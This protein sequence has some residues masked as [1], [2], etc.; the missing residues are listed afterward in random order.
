MPKPSHAEQHTSCEVLIVGAGPTGLTL[1]IELA[2][3]GIHCRIIDQADEPSRYSKALGVMARTLELLEQAGLAE[4]FTARGLPIEQVSIY[5]GKKQLAD[6]PFGQR[7]A[8]KYPYVLMLPQNETEEILL[9]RLQ[10]LGVQVERS[11]TLTA[12]QPYDATANETQ[13]TD[14]SSVVTSAATHTADVD[15]AQLA[16]RTALPHFVSGSRIQVSAASSTGQHGKP[17]TYR[18]TAT[19]VQNASS[20]SAVTSHIHAGWVVGCDG[21]HSTVRHLLRMS[22]KGTSITQDFAL[23]DVMVSGQIAHD[24]LQIYLHQG[25]IAAF[26]PMKSGRHR[27]IV[28]SPVQSQHQAEDK[29]GTGKARQISLEE[30]QQVLDECTSG[31]FTVSDPIWMTRFSVNQRKVEH[32]RSG[33]ALLAGD[34][35]HIHSPVG[36]QGMNTGMQDAFNLGWKLALVC[37]GRA[38]EMLL[39]SYEE[40]REPVARSLL[41]WTGVFTRLAINRF[42]LL[43]A[44]RNTVAPLLSSRSIVQRL[45]ARAISETDIHYRHSELVLRGENWRHGMVAPGDRAPD[46]GAGLD[47]WDN[48]KHLLLVFPEASPQLP[49]PANPE[50][51]DEDERTRIPLLIRIGDSWRSVTE[52][53]NIL[54]DQPLM[55]PQPQ[56]AHFRQD[57]GSVLRKL[58]GMEQGGYVMVRPDGYIGFAG[59]LKDEMELIGWVYRLFRIPSAVK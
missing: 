48:R 1:A 7:I 56:P 36:G 8:S 14:N 44:A 11:T 12:L 41:R 34:A 17:S 13:H 57:S 26:F 5:G 55:V 29:D 32:Y 43:A 46:A 15:S 45:M 39:D 6:V 20:D 10:Q 19:I 31:Q 35:A 24:R 51:W 23:A 16:S 9:Q 49:S 18:L 28:A 53:V 2:R 3:R 50:L 38:D 27:V 47:W 21:A 54:P 22:F 42:P 33:A 30:V 37:Q 4:E 40:E 52:I 25:R 59:S 58:Y